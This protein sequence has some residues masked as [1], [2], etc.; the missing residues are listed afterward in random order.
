M[1]KKICVLLAAITVC[2]IIC[3]ISFAASDFKDVKGTKY[4]E[5]VKNLVDI[6][7]VN[8]YAEDNTY[9]P[10]NAVTRAEMAKL[11]VI[12]LGEE[13][14]LSTAKQ[15]KNVFTDIKN[16]HW[17][18]GYVNIAKD[19]K[20]INGYPDGRFAPEDTVT[21]G[22]AV[23]MVV[24]ALGYD[25]EVEKSTE[26]W[27]N[28]YVS[29]AKKLSLLTELET[30][31]N[32]NGAKR[33]DIANLVWKTLKTGVCTV[34]SQTSSNGIVYGQGQKMLN[35]YKKYTYLNDATITSVKFS[36]DYEDAKVTITG[37]DEKLEITMSADDVLA[38]YGRKLDLLYNESNNKFSYINIVD[39]YE[40]EKYDITDVKKD[41]IYVEDD[42]DEY[43]FDLPDD[44]NILLYGVDD[45][46]DALEATLIFDG[47]KLKYVIA[48]GTVKADFGL[49]ISSDELVNKKDGIKMKKLGSSTTYS[50][51]LADEDDMPEEGS[52]IL[53][54]LNAKEEIE[55]LKEIN[56]DDSKEI[57]SSTSTK[58]K[59]DGKTYTYDEDEFVVISVDKSSIKNIDF[60]K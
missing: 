12:A 5:A 37:G 59:V 23:T 21:Y 45:I 14:K 46:D 2:L 41:V 13:G 52:V 27:P 17:A 9:R 3:S 60:N 44:D 31:D 34:K 30:F 42:E 7:L 26:A 22:E 32:D 50:Y 19:L 58:L 43:D 53:Y 36:N 8:G 38:Y 15:Q 20:I 55:I 1:N 33:G 4:E 24:R 35:K 47:K 11:M 25:V 40:T 48:S 49:V 56:V 16:E 18:Y 57:T 10:S 51:A 6:G 29:Y 54:Y 39:S 28:N